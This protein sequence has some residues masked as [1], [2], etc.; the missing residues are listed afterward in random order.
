MKQIEK[1]PKAKLENYKQKH[2][3][4]ETVLNQ[5]LAEVCERA[6]RGN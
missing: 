4:D 6:K 1:N 5:A 3:T 2:E